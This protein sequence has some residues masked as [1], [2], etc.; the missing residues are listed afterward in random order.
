MAAPD[1]STYL[2][3]HQDTVNLNNSRTIAVGTGFATTDGGSGGVLTILAAGKLASLNSLGASGLVTYNSGTSLL[4]PISLTSTDGSVGITNPTGVGGAPNFS[5]VADK[6][7]QKVQ[8]YNSTSLVSTGSKLRFLAGNNVAVS[9]A[10]NAGYSDVTISSAGVPAILPVTRGGTGLASVAAFNLLLGNGAGTLNVLAPGATAGYV[11]TSNGAGAAPSWQAGGGGGGGA[12]TDAHYVTTQANGTLTNEENLGALASGVLFSDVSSSISTLSSITP[13]TSGYV[14]TSTGPSTAPTWQPGGSGSLGP[15]LTTIASLT[16]AAGDLLVGSGVNA[17]TNL[18]KGT[19]DQYLKVN[20]SGDI[21][22]VGLPGILPNLGTVTGTTTGSL[23]VGTGASTFGNFAVSSTSG[24][25]ISSNG[26]T[27]AWITPAPTAATYITKTPSSGL[28]AEFP[29]SSMST[30][31][32]M[33]AA[34]TGDLTTAAPG[35]DYVAPSTILTSIV[36]AGSQI[37]SLLVG[38]GANTVSKLVP[39]TTSGHVLTSTGG[40]SAPTWQAVPSSGAPT[41]ATYI[42]QTPNGSLSAEFPLSGMNTGIVMVTNGTGA[43][44]TASAGTDYVAPSTILTSIVTAGA[45]AGSLLVGSNT[46]VLSKLSGSTSGFVLTSTGPTTQP[47]WQAAPATGAPVGAHYVTTQSDGTLTNEENLGNLTSGVIFSDV[48]GSVS[49][50][51]AILPTTSGYVLTST[52]PTTAPTWQVT[53]GASLGATLTTISNLTVVSGDLLVG[54]GSQSMT[55]L[56]KGTA[57]Q[58]LKVNSL[59][60][61][62]WAGLPGILPNLGTVTGTATG[63]LLVGTGSG[64]FGNFAVSSTAGQVVSSDGTTL[65]WTTPADTAA[66]Y[67]TKTSNSSLS[68]EF[69]LSTMSSGIMMV[70]TATGALSTATAGTDYVAPATILTSIVTAGSQIGSLLVGSGTDTV[71]KLAPTTSGYVLTSTGPTSAPTWQNPSAAPSAGTYLTTTDLT[72]SLPNSTN[73][74]A[75]GTGLLFSSVASGTSTVTSTIGASGTVPYSTGSAIAWRDTPTFAS[76][77]ATLTAGA[78]PTVVVLTSAVSTSPLSRIFLTPIFDGSTVVA[79]VL[80]IYPGAL[81]HGFSFTIGLSGTIASDLKVS[82][83]VVN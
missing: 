51:S 2:L 74:A 3:V 79:N 73:L 76:G 10:T 39:G 50:L 55:N 20:S 69:A 36:S 53:G 8:V 16:I 64:T 43:L 81:S 71:S 29:L 11:L 18:A 54:N 67:I 44:T 56:A 42:T 35:V 9:I 45:D 24:Q 32:M 66:T 83:M 72:A 62:V 65:A 33:V 57:E 38:S 47:S 30:G 40:S 68:N 46:N 78:N 4:S 31:I 52:G 5:V 28:S 59:G 14:L 15:T 6:T 22:W 7:V 82:W 17:M 63:S 25:V 19:T 1:N 61:I 77:T 41:N 26:T 27:L 23:L 34:S 49:T 21:V 12:P 70:T 80:P 60:N 48:S 13:T 37:G 58:F 75:Q